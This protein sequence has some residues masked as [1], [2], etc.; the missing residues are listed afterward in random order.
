MILC[1]KRAAIAAAFCAPLLFAPL[2]H[3]ADKNDKN[4]I[5][6]PLAGPR[7]T[8]LRE[9][10]LYI[11]PDA[12]TQ[13]V[14]RIQEGRE[15]VIAET[16]GPWVRVFANTDI[17]EVSEK[18]APIFGREAAI[19]DAGHFSRPRKRDT[20]DAAVSSQHRADFAVARHEA[21]HVTWYAGGM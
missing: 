3:T 8:I 10:P 9:T 17:E 15:L 19:D 6:K 7:A 4:K 12:S 11:S 14:D 16:S 20:G 21:E 2:A 18:D 1:V 13:K 5:E